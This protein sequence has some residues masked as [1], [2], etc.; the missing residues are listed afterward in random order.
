LVWKLEKAQK[1]TQGTKETRMAVRSEELRREGY[2]PVPGRVVRF[3]VDRVRA[4]AVARRRA[5]IRRRRLA[6]VALP[7]LIVAF[8]V[9]TGPGGTSVASRPS[10]PAAVVLETGETVWDLAERYAPATIDSRAYVDAVFDLNDIS[11]APAAG[12]RLRLPE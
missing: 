2:V 11:G 8:I 6:A 1:A 12:Q 10:A 3:P 9:A 5:E 7:L 4:R